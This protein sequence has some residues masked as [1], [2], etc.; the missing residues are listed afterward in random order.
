MLTIGRGVS[1]PDSSISESFV[2]SPGPGGQNVNKVATGVEL[3]CNLALCDTIPGSVLERLKRIAKS[4]ISSKEILVIQAHR[5]R[6]QERNRQDARDRLVAL[7]RKALQV[8][9]KRRATKPSRAAKA[10]RLEQKRQRSATKAMR[11]RVNTNSE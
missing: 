3:R 8:P 9:K 6:T 10:K 7:V 4:R 2:H 11:K 5:F 1:I